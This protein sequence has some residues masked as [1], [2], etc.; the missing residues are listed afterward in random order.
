MLIRRRCNGVFLF[1]AWLVGIK[2]R[3]VGFLGVDGEYI[4]CW[5]VEWVG[6]LVPRCL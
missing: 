2:R 3:C 5:R 4:G 1:G 6:V